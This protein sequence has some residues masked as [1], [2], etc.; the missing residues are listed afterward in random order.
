[1][2]KIE[3]KINTFQFMIDNR[4]VIIETIKENLSI[5]K[6]WD[7][8]KEKLPATQKVVKFNTFKG[9]VKALNVVNHI[10]NE[11]DEILR[12]KQKLSEE[13]GRVRQEK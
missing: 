1:M 6:A 12:D 4:K 8:L 11:K 2:G 9:Y 7:Q 5:P 13:I 10:M 3:N